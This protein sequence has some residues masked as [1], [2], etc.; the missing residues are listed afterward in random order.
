LHKYLRAIGF[1]SIQK[2]KDYENL[3]RFCAQDATS[4]SYTTKSPVHSKTETDEDTMLAVF[5]KDFADGI[6]L[7]VCG[8]YDEKN[9]FSYDYCFPYL[10]G[11]GIASYEDITIERHAE[12]ESYAGICDDSKIGITMIFYLQNMIPYIKAKNSDTLPVTGTSLTLSAL[13]CK[14]S[15]MMPLKKNEQ[16]IKKTKQAAMSRSRLIEAA[17]RGDESAIESLT[18][19]DMDM[20]TS[21]S[22]KIHQNDIYTIVDTYFMPYGVECDQYS[23]MGEILSCELVENRITNEQ[24]YKMKLL[25]NDLT[26]D[27]CINKLDLYGEPLE[28]RR[29]KGVIWLQGKINFPD[30]ESIE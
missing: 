24:I 10:R 29:F 16:D 27:I 7:S 26:F 4:R 2:R 13:S 15:I 18:L 5:S 9:H 28:G 25:C 6:G 20:Y 12:K 17:K 22:K 14:G 1:S 19:E 3:I 11:E 8:E 21:I 30:N 23:I